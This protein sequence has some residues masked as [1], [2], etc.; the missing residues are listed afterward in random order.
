MLVTYRM[1]MA[2]T[3][4]VRDMNR[5]LVY[6]VDNKAAAALTRL[7]HSEH[8]EVVGFLTYGET[9]NRKT[10]LGLPICTFSSVE[11]IKKLKEGMNL[12]GILFAYHADLRK[13]QER[14]INYAQDENLKLFIAPAI[15]EVNDSKNIAR[16][17]RKIKIED[18]LGRQEI[19]ISMDEIRNGLQG[20]TVLVTGAAGSIGSELCRQIARLGIKK[21]IMLDNAETPLH[22]VRLEFEDNYKDLVFI[23]VIGDVRS[24]E[25]LDYIFREFRPQIVYHA[26]AYKHVPLMEENPCEAILVN[27]DGSRNVADKCVEYGV[28]KMVMISTD[29]AVNPTNIMGCTKRLAEIYVQSLGLGIEKGEVKGNTRFVTTRFGNVLGSNGS[30]IPRFTEQIEHGGPVTVTDPE[31]RRFFMT[32]PEACRL[33]MEAAT[34]SSGTQI[35]VF[36]MGTPIKISD[37]AKKMIHLAGYRPCIDIQI[38]YT[39][40]RPGEK[41]YEEVLATKEN[42]IPTEHHRIFVA[43][44][45]EYPYNSA[46]ESVNRLTQLGRK[47]QMEEMVILMKKI[48]PEFKSKHSVF[49][50]YD[51]TECI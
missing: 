32:I 15:D 20:K 2:H 45:R 29:K 5:V 37:L 36:D 28:E 8:Y 14:L 42:T 11:D 44:V 23:P 25:R 19:K 12:T 9:P 13:E 43:K 18:L 7:R 40:L 16:G 50:K 39:G 4:Q 49:E 35:F 6:G 17:I 51:K 24:R 31:I 27:V 3:R 1:M 21:L 33:V 22:N 10:L 38:E 48:V 26:A 30:V 34:I 41:L 46:V 47:V